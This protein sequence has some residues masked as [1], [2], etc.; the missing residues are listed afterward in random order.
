MAWVPI[1]LPPAD[2]C[3]R[4]YGP[5][6]SRFPIEVIYKVKNPLNDHE[7]SLMMRL[8]YWTDKPNQPDS[9]KE[10]VHH[11]GMTW[12]ASRWKDNFTPWSAYVPV[13]EQFVAQLV[14]TS[15]LPKRSV[16][17][18]SLVKAIIGIAVGVILMWVFY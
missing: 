8:D 9:P 3:C 15:S 2:H 10:I 11:Q 18:S 6:S 12:E 5:T 4:R 14:N 1:V 17:K 16:L 7:R 13:R